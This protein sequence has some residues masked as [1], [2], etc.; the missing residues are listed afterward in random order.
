MNTNW[1]FIP[2]N[3]AAEGSELQEGSTGHI[4]EK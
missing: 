1:V 2:V 3:E 4:I